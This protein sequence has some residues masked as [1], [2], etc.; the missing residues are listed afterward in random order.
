MFVECPDTELQLALG[1]LAVFLA[2]GVFGFVMG[3]LCHQVR[4]I[5]RMNE[6]H[7][8]ETRAPGG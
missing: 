5:D 2:G 7:A 3:F 4:E 1:L 8:R 6:R